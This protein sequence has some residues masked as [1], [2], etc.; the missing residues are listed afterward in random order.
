MRVTIMCLEVQSLSVKHY[1]KFKSSLKSAGQQIVM[2]PFKLGEEPLSEMRFRSGIVKHVV[3][4]ETH[5]MIFLAK[6]EYRFMNFSWILP[7][8]LLTFQTFLSLVFSTANLGISMAI[9]PWSSQRMVVKRLAQ[10]AVTE[11]L[12]RWYHTAPT[13]ACIGETRVSPLPLGLFAS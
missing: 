12:V 1:T 3:F 9:A 11:G 4:P 7:R 8:L 2:F 13:V 10:A 5:K 6:T